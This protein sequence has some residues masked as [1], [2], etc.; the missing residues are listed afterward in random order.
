MR[1]HRG[2]APRLRPPSAGSDVETDRPRTG[3]DAPDLGEIAVTS[4]R[5]LHER[6][7]LNGNA[8]DG[9]DRYPMDTALGTTSSR[10]GDSGLRSSVVVGCPW[11]GGRSA[12]RRGELAGGVG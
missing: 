1:R 2:A 8:G 7:E 3:M 12:P 11:A 9:D 5:S 6:V 4:C 10:P